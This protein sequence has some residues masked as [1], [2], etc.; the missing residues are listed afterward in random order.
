MVDVPMATRGVVSDCRALQRIVPGSPRSTGAAHVWGTAEVALALGGW[1]FG[2]A[3]GDD[4]GVGGSSFRLLYR[5]HQRR[6]VRDRGLGVGPHLGAVAVVA[7]GSNRG[8]RSFAVP[9]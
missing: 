1:R 9:D 8:C 6:A 2:P 5:G 3:R 4:D 7:L